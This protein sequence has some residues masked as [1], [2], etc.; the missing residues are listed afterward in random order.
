MFFFQIPWLP[1]FIIGLSDYQ[2]LADSLQG[3]N[4]G[5]GFKN[6]QAYYSDD[7]VQLVKYSACREI[8]Y[9]I[10]Y[11]RASKLL[12]VIFLFFHEMLE[13]VHLQFKS[14]FISIRKVNL[15]LQ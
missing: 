15:F 14:C 12:I 9:P 6:S 3:R 1:E 7:E 8:R 4:E 5:M 11:Y 10:N 2:G 13:I